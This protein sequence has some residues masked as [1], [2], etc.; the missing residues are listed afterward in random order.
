VRYRSPVDAL[1]ERNYREALQERLQD[2][3]EAWRSGDAG[4]LSRLEDALATM[5]A[6]RFGIPKSS[7]VKLWTLESQAAMRGA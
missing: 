4:A 6:Q 1:F 5:Q 3:L 2:A 7:I